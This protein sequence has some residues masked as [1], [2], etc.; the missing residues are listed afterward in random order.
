MIDVIRAS[1]VK[2]KFS[3]FFHHTEPVDSSFYLGKSWGLSEVLREIRKYG[4]TCQ[5]S[6]CHPAQLCNPATPKN[7]FLLLNNKIILW[8]FYSRPAKYVALCVAWLLCFTSA[9]IS[10][11]IDEV[12]FLKPALVLVGL[13]PLSQCKLSLHVGWKRN[14]REQ[15]VLYIGRRWEEL[16]IRQ[17]KIFF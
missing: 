11:I 10:S 4:S 8:Y 1:F 16:A 2:F 15:A 9:V 17:L 14:G 12:W 5:E 3:L 6:G 7:I 13:L